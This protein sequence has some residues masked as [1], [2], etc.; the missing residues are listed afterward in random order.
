MQLNA[1]DDD[2]LNLNLDPAAVAA[3]YARR[4]I[5]L[6][7]GPS[8]AAEPILNVAPKQVGRHRAVEG[9][10]RP[11]L[12]DRRFFEMIQAN[13]PAPDH[14]SVHLFDATVHRSG[15]LQPRHPLRAA[16]QVCAD[17]L[18]ELQIA[19]QEPIDTRP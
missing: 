9:A 3:A 19:E 11:D 7:A 5:K 6:E 4:Q 13:R 1:P 14:M 10:V 17:D 2:A 15:G 18:A 12:H 16:D 8:I